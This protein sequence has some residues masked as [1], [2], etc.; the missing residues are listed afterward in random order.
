MSDL[1]ILLVLASAMPAPGVALAQDSVPP[2]GR[3][4]ASPR[5]PSG[6]PPL[7]NSVKV[8]LQYHYDEENEFQHLRHPGTPF[9]LPSLGSQEGQN[10][11]AFDAD[12]YFKEPKRAGPS[13]TF[14][15]SFG[16]PEVTIGAPFSGRVRHL[17]ETYISGDP[18]E[19]PTPPTETRTA[20]PT[21]VAST[22]ATSRSGGL[23][24]V[25][26]DVED[27]DRPLM[28]GPTMHLLLKE[29]LS[30]WHA[31]A[32]APKHTALLLY[33]RALLGS[34]EIFDTDVDM[35]LFSV[36]PR[37]VIPLLGRSEGVR[38][39]ATLSGGPAWLRT[40]VGD[41]YGLELAGGIQTSVG[42]TTSVAFTLGLEVAAFWTEGLFSWGPVPTLGFDVRW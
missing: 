42:V 32:W 9:R 39:G 19:D 5:D 3:R 37:L 18:R 33:A 10:E 29:N 30:D 36:G 17:I 27:S 15:M 8:K 35:Q 13:V 16:A 11:F 22:S 31:T 4:P 21:S 23:F 14:S 7:R 6:S 2:E 26:G 20:L 34:M 12:Y 38:I 40:D 1:L 28:Y 25:G 24:G 41:A